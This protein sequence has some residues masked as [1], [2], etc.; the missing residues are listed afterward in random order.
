M[1]GRFG[2]FDLV[3]IHW[4]FVCAVQTARVWP[5]PLR[6][7]CMSSVNG[8]KRKK[9]PD[10]A[11]RMWLGFLAVLPTLMAGELNPRPEHSAQAGLADLLDKVGDVIGRG[12]CW[13]EAKFGLRPKNWPPTPN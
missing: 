4:N 6:T 3:F 2:R 13:L 9:Q 12:F 1:R 11:N 8:E 10:L 7:Q 5:Q